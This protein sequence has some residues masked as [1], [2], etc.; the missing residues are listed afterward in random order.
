[1]VPRRSR[2]GSPRSTRRSYAS[3]VAHASRST[4]APPSRYDVGPREAALDHRALLE[5][6]LDAPHPWSPRLGIAFFGRPGT[7]RL[8]APGGE[9]PLHLG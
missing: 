6:R 7:E 5:V 2:C 4:L 9:A 3:R 8:G 1:M